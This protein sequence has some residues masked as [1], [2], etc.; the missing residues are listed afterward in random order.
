MLGIVESK[1]ANRQICTS[2]DLPGLLKEAPHRLPRVD[3]V[4]FANP[5]KE[6]VK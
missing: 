5:N 4:T 6:V 2:M 1:P 3:E